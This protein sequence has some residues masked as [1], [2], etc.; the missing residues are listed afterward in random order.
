MTDDIL[1]KANENRRKYQDCE[2]L[3]ALVTAGA[4]EDIRVSCH[5]GS[6]SLAS[7]LK[8]SFIEMM[9][10]YLNNEMDILNKEYEEL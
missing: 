8:K 6:F 3:L 10:S 7:E 4:N 2:W 9:A 1:E 5:N